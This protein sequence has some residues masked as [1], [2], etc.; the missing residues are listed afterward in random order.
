MHDSCEVWGVV[1]GGFR[2]LV[3]YS[4]CNCDWMNTKA[5]YTSSDAFT[6]WA[7]HRRETINGID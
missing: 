7:R 5:K 1:E 2:G 3:W 4:K 6:E